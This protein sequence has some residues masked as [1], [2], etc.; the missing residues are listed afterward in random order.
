MVGGGQQTAACAKHQTNGEALATE[1]PNPKSRAWCYTLNNYT[2]EEVEALQGV[3]ERGETSVEYLCFGKE[4]GE[5][6]TPHLQGYVRF[7]SQV[8]MATVKEAVG[9]RAHVEIARG[10][11]QQ[12]LDYCRKDGDFTE[13]GR[14]PM[15]QSDKG[16]AEKRRYEDAWEAALEGRMDDIDADLRIRHYSTI[17]RIRADA[18]NAQ[19]LEDTTE[20]ML[21]FTGP[22]GTGKSRKARDDYPGLFIKPINKWWD[23]YTDEDTVLLDDFDKRHSVLSYHLKIWADRYPFRAEIKGGTVMI[24]PRRIIVTS[25]WTPQEIWDEDSTGDLE[26]I[27]R[28]FKVIH[29]PIADAP[30]ADVQVEVVDD[31][32]GM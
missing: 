14:R 24:R 30:A 1:M 17:K 7:K 25:N 22:S 10:N 26:P 31:D 28:R 18:L 5:S 15:T 23:G 6:G 8:R 11:V 4:V 19:A 12:N 20:E 3:V 29:F 2:D 27:L 32:D 16:A 21:W 9:N 13:V